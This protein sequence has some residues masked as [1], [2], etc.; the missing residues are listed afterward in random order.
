MNP[1]FNSSV[2][3]NRRAELANQIGSGIIVLL[4]NNE[5]PM[6]YRS[7]CYRY[8]Q[9]STFLYFFGLSVPDLAAV[10]DVD[11]NRTLIFGDD[12][13]ID[14][15]IW[16][17]NQPAIRTLA[18]QVGVTE[19]MPKKNL[20][21]FLARNKHRDIHFTLPYR[22]DNKIELS[23][24]LD[25]PISNLAEKVSVKLTKAIVALRSIKEDRELEEM[26]KACKIAYDMHTSVMHACKTGVSEQHLVGLAEGISLQNGNGPSFQIILTQHGEI[27]HN[28]DHNVDLQKGRLLLMDAGAESLMN[29]CSDSTRT[30]PV[31]GQFTQKQKEIYEIVLKGN[32]TGIDMVKAGIP[33][34]DVHF[35][36][37]EVVADGLKTLGLM[38]GDV[39]EAVRLGAHALFFPHGLGHMVGL[40]VHDMENLGEDFVGYDD[41]YKR[42]EIFG[43][44]NLRMARTLKPNM[45]ITVEPG[46]YF[47][48][49]L[50]QMWKKENHLTQFINY[51]KVLDYLDFGGIRIEDCV[52]VTENGHKILGPHLPKSV[53]ELSEIVGK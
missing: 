23:Q 38:K 35:A 36:V 41:I 40:D 32:M 33:Y 50:I 12:F 21:D 3:A 18:E 17:G 2:Y 6:N 42:S 31:G 13:T 51:E 20:H 49:A 25:M 22:H 27:F 43:T 52:C 28:L 9:D 30:M 4:G 5:A 53:D 26:E 16:V 14:D 39:K 46:I 37:A 44:A 45:V 10:I 19:T 48:P 24:L 11:E 47:I 15:I 1:L 34:R 8:R 29:Y 7:N